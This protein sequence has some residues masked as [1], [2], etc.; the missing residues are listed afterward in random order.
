MSVLEPSNVPPIPISEHSQVLIAMHKA[1]RADSRRLISAVDALP[2]GDT[3]EATALGRAFAAIVGLIHDHHW[4][5]DDVMYPFLLQ[6]VPGFESDTLRLE[7]DHVELD[8]AMAR[9]NARFR[10]LAHQLSARLWQDT[11]GHLL[12]EAAAFDRVLVDHLDREEALVV[13]PFESLLSEPTS[14]PCRRRRPSSAPTG[15][16]AWP[17]PGSWPTPPRKRRPACEQPLPVCSVSS[18]T[19]SGSRGSPASWP[20]CT[21]RP[22]PSGWWAGGHRASV[23]R[24]PPGG[25]SAEPPGSA[26]ATGGRRG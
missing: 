4:T 7:N 23:A 25:R 13:P 14:T 21:S 17:C 26:T 2:A 8:A 5:E 9:I 24:G 18:R 12:E 6:R 15:T 1:M 11:R 10:L 22:R 19:E 16:C 20:R 3:Q